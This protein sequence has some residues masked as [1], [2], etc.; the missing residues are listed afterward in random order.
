[1]F[2]EWASL[3][4]LAKDVKKEIA[5]LVQNENEKTINLIK[6]LEEDLKQ[7]TAEIKKRDFYFYKTGV[8]EAKKKLDAIYEE[9]KIFEEKIEDYGYNA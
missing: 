2:D 1:M 8:E 4:K 5:P 3:K 7:F 6:K 9:V